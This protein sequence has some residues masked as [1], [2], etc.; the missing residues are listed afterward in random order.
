MSV[1]LRMVGGAS[2]GTSILFRQISIAWSDRARTSDG[3]H[4]LT[5]NER[6]AAFMTEHVE[7]TWRGRKER[8]ADG[9]A[10]VM[11][12]ENHPVRRGGC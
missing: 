4:K 11:I 2:N 5:T 9:S 6:R 8:I 12:A 1:G 10:E 3:A 7:D